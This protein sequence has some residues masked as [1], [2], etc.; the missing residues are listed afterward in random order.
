MLQRSRGEPKDPIPRACRR[1]ARRVLPLVLAAL[2]PAAGRAE[3]P[4]QAAE[5]ARRSPNQPRLGGVE[6]PARAP[7]PPAS[8]EP[9]R[10]PGELRSIDGTGNNPFEPEWGSA[11]TAFLR[12]ARTGYADGLGAPAGAD[13]AVARAVSNR[14]VAQPGYIPNGRAVNDLFWQWGQFLDHDLDLTPV[15]APA[16][17]FD[18]PV[19]A[20][21][22]WFD[23]G[24]S[25]TELIPLDRSLHVLIDGVREQL[26]IIT[27]YIDASNVYG[28]DPERASALRRL[29]GSGRLK[30]GPGELLPFNEAGLPNA[31]VR[32][33]E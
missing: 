14:C 18:I 27:A 26:N 24:W 5:A 6:L 28:S 1:C 29:D 12:L 33:K 20:G 19:P 4:S 22:P 3:S 17:A 32:L 21:D 30:T 31:L 2:L 8:F 13:R 15:A 16:E 10:F 9:A 11:G 25:G 7:L 23:P